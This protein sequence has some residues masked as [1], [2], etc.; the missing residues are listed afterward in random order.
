MI[1]VSPDFGPGI[2]FRGWDRSCAALAADDFGG[3]EGIGFV[4]E[5]EID[6]PD[7]ISPGD[8]SERVSTFAHGLIRISI[9]RIFYAL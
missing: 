8:L 4:E 2:Y 3:E 9:P 5:D 7:A 6:P 1:D